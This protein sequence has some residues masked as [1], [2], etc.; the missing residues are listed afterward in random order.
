MRARRSGHSRRRRRGLPDGTQGHVLHLYKLF[1]LVYCST[2]H[3]QSSLLSSVCLVSLYFLFFKSS[4]YKL[5]SGNP[6]TNDRTV[7][8]MGTC[9]VPL[10]NMYLHRYNSLLL[11]LHVSRMYHISTS[12]KHT[13]YI[14][15]TLNNRFICSIKILNTSLLYSIIIII[16]N[17]IT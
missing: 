2:L 8:F 4:I 6:A 13:M 16:Y 11:E 1:F 3:G 12:Y 15:K 14:N 7:Q 9:L 5:S 17:G 10:Y